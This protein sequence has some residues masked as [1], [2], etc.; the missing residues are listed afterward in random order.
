MATPDT[1]LAHTPPQMYGDHAAPRAT[2]TVV[3]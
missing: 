2:P 3:S 1:I